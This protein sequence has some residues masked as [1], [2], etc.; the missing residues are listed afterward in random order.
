VAGDFADPDTQD[1]AIADA[2]RMG[3]DDEEIEDLRAELGRQSDRRLWGRHVD[4][5]RALCAAGTQWRRRLMFTP[6]GPTEVVAGL[7]YVALKVATDALGIV[8][9]AASWRQLMVLERASAAAMNGAP[10]PPE[11]L[12]E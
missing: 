12:P 6:A 1:D 2:R 3:L 5:F 10:P 8:L 4:A 7:D 9:S 11:M